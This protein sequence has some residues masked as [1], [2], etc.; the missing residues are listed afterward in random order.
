MPGSVEHF[1]AEFGT[2]FDKV[3]LGTA[4]LASVELGSLLGV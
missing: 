2:L 4:T 3:T 1:S